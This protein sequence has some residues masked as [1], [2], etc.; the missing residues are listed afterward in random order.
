MPRAEA[1]VEEREK[2]Q[3]G[4]R[5]EWL[6][7]MPAWAVSA[8]I[9]LGLIVVAISIVSERM[10]PLPDGGTITIAMRPLEPRQEAKPLPYRPE[11]RREMESFPKPPKED[12]DV[13]LPFII[14]KDGTDDSATEIPKGTSLNNRGSGQRDFSS[15]EL[16]DFDSPMG[17][18]E[19]V[20]A[21]YGR[22]DG[23]DLQARIRH[24]GRPGGESVIHAA[25]E[26]LRR[27]QSA[28][29]SWKSHD[30]PE[31]CKTPCRNVDPALY[32]DGRGFAG[33]DVGVTGLAVLAFAGWG[34]THETGDYTEFVA[35]VRKAVGFLR[36]VQVRSEDPSTNGRLG[37]ASGEQW[38]YDHAIATMALAELLVMSGD[39]VGL[40]KPVRDAVR[41]CLHARNDGFGWRYGIKP[42]E[43]DTSVTGWMVLALKA[44]KSAQI[45][46]PESEMN[47]ALGGALTWIHRA[48][49]TNGKTGYL[50][51]GDEGSRL[52]SAQS[53]PYPYSKE[54]S[55]MTAV[56]VL[57]RLFAG[58]ARSRSEVR[59][60]VRILMKD[61][62]LCREAKGRSLST[63]NYDYW[64]Y[65]SY[66][67][68]QYMTFGK[69]TD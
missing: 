65:G 69:N 41:L 11:L 42:G 22:L 39:A 2:P 15:P 45:D 20:G 4:V 40:K 9:H 55:S 30:F 35:C 21:P 66:A 43:N 53:E 17:L 12:P 5:F 19:T 56:G 59:G 37:A 1:L 18:G 34:H 48:T 16:P 6:R 68:F 63:I 52:S 3:Q 44:A 24:L 50:A 23:I 10:Q 62:P 64:Y 60:G 26:W 13:E 49:A 14:T 58:Q 46:I 36:R 57:C 31:S 7:A 8:V 33:H 27:H 54:L 29:G 61:P 47:E 32:G 51:P 28:D 38:I 25:L 67:L